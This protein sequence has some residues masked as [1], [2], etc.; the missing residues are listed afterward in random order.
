MTGNHF[1]PKL[2]HPKLDARGS[3]KVQVDFKVL[4]LVGCDLICS[5]GKGRHLVRPSLDQEARTFEGRT[6]Q[7][8]I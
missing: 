1:G 2:F 8:C 5:Q 3:I 7:V 4:C 6:Q